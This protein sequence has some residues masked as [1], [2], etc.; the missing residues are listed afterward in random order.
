LISLKTPGELDAIAAAGSIL[1]RLF[2][3]IRGVVEPDTTTAR[4]DAFAEEFIR[5]HPGAE[6]AFK[7]LYGFPASL[8]TSVNHEVVH[9]IPSSRRHLE[10][11]D[12]VSIDAGVKLDG[13]FADMAVTV[14]VGETEPAT[15]RLLAVTQTALRAGIA[16]A[17]A[18]NRVGD[19]GHAVQTV[20]EAAGFSVVRELVGHGLGREPHEE[21]QVPNY[22][23][24]GRGL[25]L[26]PGLVI[27]IEPMVN[28]GGPEVR[29]LSDRWTVVTADRRR[30]AHFE[31]TIAVTEAGPR[32]LTE[33]VGTASRVGR[34]GVLRSAEG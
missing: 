17:L 10:S 30:S 6:P 15:E 8:C 4:L 1:A 20:A 33:P 22:G 3:E 5:S 25:R 32:I 11:G 28:E 31:H 16:A 27:A 18:G 7:G 29:T 26:Q 13:W 19:I 9:G 14:A 34:G 23:R 24:R 21:P 2:E 12:I